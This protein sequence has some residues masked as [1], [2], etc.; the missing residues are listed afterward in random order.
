MSSLD[1]RCPHHSFDRTLVIISLLDWTNNWLSLCLRESSSSAGSATRLLSRRNNTSQSDDLPPS[2][3]TVNHLHNID[4]V[5]SQAEPSY[6]D[7]V[8]RGPGQASACQRG[9]GTCRYENVD[10]EKPQYANVLPKTG[11]RYKADDTEHLNVQPPA[12]SDP[13][14]KRPMLLTKDRAG[15]RSMDE[16]RYLDPGEDMHSTSP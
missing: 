2:N 13:S 3:R 6:S 12:S 8:H 1:C 10:C 15:T 4:E 5:F 7:L 11:C 16:L 9:V 14:P